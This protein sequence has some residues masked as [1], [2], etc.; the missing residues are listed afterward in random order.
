MLMPWFALLIFNPILRGGGWQT[1]GEEGRSSTR[2]VLQ[3]FLTPR[4]LTVLLYAARM[5]WDMT[6][7]EVVAQPWTLL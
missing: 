2:T 1:V 4:F 3:S 7:G 5:V 6:E